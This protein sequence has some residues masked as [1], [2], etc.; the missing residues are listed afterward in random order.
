MSIDLCLPQRFYESRQKDDQPFPS[1]SESGTEKISTLYSRLSRVYFWSSNKK[2]MRCAILK[3]AD[4]QT[5]VF[6]G[7]RVLL[8]V[9]E[10][11]D[12]KNILNRDIIV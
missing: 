12:C 7:N 5:T 10:K 1:D 4:L 11:N 9:P 6:D 2:G 3:K 8:F